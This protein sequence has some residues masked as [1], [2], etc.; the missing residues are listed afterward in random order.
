MIFIVSAIALGL[1]L[2]FAYEYVE[3]LRENNPDVLRIRRKLEP[4]FPEMRNVRLL[5]GESSYTVDKS[6]IY[7]CT[8]GDKD[9]RLYDD[10]TL[11][12]VFLH[13]LAHSLN[14]EKIGHGD[15]FRNIFNA[16]LYRAEKNNLYDSSRPPPAN[17]CS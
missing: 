4:F 3:N 8:R 15:E 10:N 14:K 2:L 1:S 11:T 16:L 17:Y 12:Y 13:E 5:K 6:K 7:L 9:R